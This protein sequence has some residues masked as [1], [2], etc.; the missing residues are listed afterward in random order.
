M[1]AT[2]LWHPATV[3]EATLLYRIA[4]DPAV[5]A[6]AQ[7]QLDVAM[8]RMLDAAPADLHARQ[9][10]AKCARDIL[11]SLLGAPQVLLSMRTAQA[12]VLAQESP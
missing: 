5:H 4:Q 2:R 3:E 1:S 11:D 12:N 6:F 7:R 8:D 10:Y 9:V